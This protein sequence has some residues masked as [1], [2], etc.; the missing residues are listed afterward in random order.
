M[1]VMLEDQ[2]LDAAQVV[3]SHTLVAGQ[4]DNWLQPELAVAISST[5]VDVRRLVSFIGVKVKPE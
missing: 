2:L 1:F 3:R 4:A 5:N